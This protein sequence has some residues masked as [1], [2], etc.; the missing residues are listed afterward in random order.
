LHCQ[1]ADQFVAFVLSTSEAAPS[2]DM[3]VAYSFLQIS[4]SLIQ[5]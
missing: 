1:T 4:M 2:L 3:A 5:L